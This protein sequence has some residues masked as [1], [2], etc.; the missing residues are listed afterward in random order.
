MKIKYGV[1][2][3]FFTEIDLHYLLSSYQTTKEL[4]VLGTV[5]F[6][7]AIPDTKYIGI[8]FNA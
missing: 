8:A 4:W 2:N 6:F 3:F 7:A 1:G 5:T